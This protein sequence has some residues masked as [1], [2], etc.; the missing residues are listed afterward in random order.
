MIDWAAFTFGVWVAV[1][2]ALLFDFYNGVNDAANSIATV[3]ATRALPPV[4]AVGLAA[5]FNF[6]G[7]FLGT[8]VAKTVGSGIVFSEFIDTALILGTVIG[9][10]V[11]TAVASYFGIP[12]SV[13]HALLGGLVGAGLAKVGL[14]AVQWP[15][16]I[17][18]LDTFQI[19]FLGAA[20]GVV[21]TLTLGILAQSRKMTPAVAAGVVFGS[22][23][24]LVYTIIAGSLEIG[25]VWGTVL[26][27]FY[28]PIVSFVGSY[29]FV[30]GLTWA[31]QKLPPAKTNK[32]FRW[33]Q[34]LSSSAFSLGHGTN[35]AQK[36]MGILAAL[37]FANGAIA[38]FT[39]EWE[40]I[41]AAAT[42]IALGTFIGGHKVVRTMGHR[43][44]HLDPYQ[45][46]AAETAGALNLFFLADNGVPAST[47]HTIG[48]AIMGVGASKSVYAVSWGLARNIMIAWLV[49]IPVAA[50]VAGGAYYLVATVF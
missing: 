6:L 22:A 40:I 46:F 2:L 37:L 47:T 43:L 11:W 16:V 12:I 1:F 27:I 21:I 7:A 36:T 38:S 31:V 14:A 50:V 48:G 8:A 39:I 5:F 45:G 4:A 13:S 29:L 32:W 17:E 49:T 42:A 10:I 34:I 20:I 25:K 23:V 35:D 44:T 41:V 9:G 28:A 3:V 15:T 33:L 18:I 24:A 26:F 19:M 30:I